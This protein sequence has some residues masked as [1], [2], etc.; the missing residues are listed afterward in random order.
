[1]LNNHVDHWNHNG[2]DIKGSQD[3]L[4]E[5]NIG[6]DEPD[7]G[8]AF[9]TE[10][11]TGVVFRNNAAYDISNG[12]Q[13]SVA[14]SASILNN[15]ITNATTVLYFGPRANSVFVRAN[16]ANACVA[17]VGT[18]GRGILQQDDNTWR[19]SHP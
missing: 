5:G 16:S 8:A 2:V 12:F 13:I 17:A 7:D 18:D 10:Y 1:V 11:S 6:C 3:V 9:Y 15:S 14:A 4:V 19:C